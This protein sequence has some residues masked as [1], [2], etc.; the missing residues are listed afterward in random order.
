[1]KSIS[2][3]SLR[4]NLSFVLNTVEK[5]HIPYHIIRKNHKNTILLTEEDYESTQETLDL[6]LPEIQDYSL[7]IF[8]FN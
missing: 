5:D 7:F 4:K 3:T 8:I 2:Y 6:L 1:M